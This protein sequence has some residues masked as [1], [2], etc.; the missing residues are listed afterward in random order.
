LTTP[1]VYDG[2]PFRGM[3]HG[4]NSKKAPFRGRGWLA[5]PGVAGSSQSRVFLPK[6]LEVA[7]TEEDAAKK[8]IVQKRGYKN[9]K[10]HNRSN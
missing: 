5:E 9:A 4:E 7:M 10:I 6:S 3:G 8:Y 2:T 1:T